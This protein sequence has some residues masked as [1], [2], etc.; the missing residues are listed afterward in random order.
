MWVEL[1]EKWGGNWKDHKDLGRGR[2]KSWKNHLEQPVALEGAWNCL[3][4]SQ[5]RSAVRGLL[6]FAGFGAKEERSN[7]CT[8]WIPKCVTAPQSIRAGY[9]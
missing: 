7:L 4:P 1:E 3:V 6:F 5:P 2:A 8:A 9:S